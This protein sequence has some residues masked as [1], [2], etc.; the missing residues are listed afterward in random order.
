MALKR[1]IRGGLDAPA[2]ARAAVGHCDA[3]LGWRAGDARMIVSELVLNAWQHGH[4]LDARPIGLT[5]TTI[6]DGGIRIEVRDGGE[7][8]D[9]DEAIADTRPHEPGWGL[10]IIRALS[11]DWG[12][13]RNRGTCVWATVLPRPEQPRL[14]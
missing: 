12:V 2:Q 5:L 4:D 6:D 14:A 1:T 13:E 8:F 3:D 10:T 7:G 9:V 11:D